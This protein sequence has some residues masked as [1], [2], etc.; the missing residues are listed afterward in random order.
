MCVCTCSMELSNK[1]NCQHLRP[2][3][4]WPRAVST[5]VGCFR[6]LLL[7]G[8][9]SQNTSSH[10]TAQSHFNTTV[11]YEIYI[12]MRDHSTHV[13]LIHNLIKCYLVL[14]GVTAGI[15]IHHQGDLWNNMTGTVY[16]QMAIIRRLFTKS[17][18]FRFMWHF[19]TCFYSLLSRSVQMSLQRNR[20]AWP[21]KNTANLAP[22]HGE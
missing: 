3:Y 20:F 8:R 17:S 2:L 16:H 14:W 15:F 7:R 10:F 4:V 1:M 19:G 5:E 18:I 12:Y 21:S 13:T 6:L 11:V 9:V 22:S